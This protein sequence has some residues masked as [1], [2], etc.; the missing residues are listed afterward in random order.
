MSGRHRFAPPAAAG[1][2]PSLRPRKPNRVPWHIRIIS[3]IRLH[4]SLSAC[5]RHEPTSISSD[6]L[7]LRYSECQ[8]PILD[9]TLWAC[10]GK[11]RPAVLEKIEI[12]PQFGWDHCLASLSDGLVQAEWPDGHRWSSKKPGLEVRALPNGPTAADSPVLR[13]VRMRNIARRFSS[14][15]ADPDTGFKD[16][17][18]L[19]P[20]P[21]CRYSDPD[22]ALLNGAIFAFSS[23]G[24]GPDLL[25]LVELHGRVPTLLGRHK[26]NTLRTAGCRLRRAARSRCRQARTPVRL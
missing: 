9:G 19:L 7:L 20:Q 8:M 11:G 17:Q 1:E 3:Y 4:S 14:T 16:R 21:V 12:Y 13:P 23:A 5:K 22:S 10:G 26:R 24:T 18:R 25:I 15:V 2:P 6:E